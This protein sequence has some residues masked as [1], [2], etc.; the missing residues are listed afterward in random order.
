VYLFDSEY[1]AASAAKANAMSAKSRSS[2][3][4]ISYSSQ[5]LPALSVFRVTE[6]KGL[7]VQ[8]CLERN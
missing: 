5:A 2:R 4:N 1:C 8:A 3:I 7:Q 6:S